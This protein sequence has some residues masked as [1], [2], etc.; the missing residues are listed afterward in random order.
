MHEPDDVQLACDGLS[1][2]LDDL[3]LFPKYVSL[4]DLLVPVAVSA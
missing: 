2:C 1:I 3:T 4:S